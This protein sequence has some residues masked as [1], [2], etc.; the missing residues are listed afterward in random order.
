M[1][2]Y[3]CVPVCLLDLFIFVKWYMCWLLVSVIIFNLFKGVCSKKLFCLCLYLFFVCF[4]ILHSRVCTQKFKEK[5][6]IGFKMFAQRYMYVDMY[7]A[8]Y[9]N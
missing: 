4:F 1:C 2:A 8:G 3:M 7:S 9:F 5:Q 6:Q